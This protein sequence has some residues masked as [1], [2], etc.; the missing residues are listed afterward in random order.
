M[1]SASS[2]SAATRAGDQAWAKMSK[3]V[4]LRGCFRLSLCPSYPSSSLPTSPPL[5]FRFAQNAELFNLTYGAMVMQL[6][7]DYEDVQSV[8]QQLEK[9]Y[10]GLGVVVCLGVVG[11]LPPSASLAVLGMCS[12]LLRNGLEAPQ[13]S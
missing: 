12:F 1:S 6:I 13:W 9:M 2:R 8:N 3:M 11:W 7:R 5:P 4:R 10:V